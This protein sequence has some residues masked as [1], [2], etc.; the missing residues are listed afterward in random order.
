LACILI[1]DTPELIAFASADIEQN[2][3]EL[4][5]HALT[6]IAKS[7]FEHVSRLASV[8]DMR[9]FAREAAA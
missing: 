3:Y 1:A 9:Q 4:Q 6:R 5:E 7:W 2:A 8:E